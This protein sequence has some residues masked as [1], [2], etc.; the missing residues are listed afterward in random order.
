MRVITRHLKGSWGE[1]EFE[2][3]GDTAPSQTSP[4]RGYNKTGSPNCVWEMA[5][6]GGGGLI[7]RSPKGDKGRGGGHRCQSRQPRPLT[8]MNLRGG[9]ATPRAGDG[10]GVNFCS[11]GWAPSKTTGHGAWSR[12]GR[13][14]ESK[15]PQSAL[16]S[17][18][19]F[20][21]QPSIPT[22]N[23]RIV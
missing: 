22:K 7:E 14:F 6:G 10:E 1:I 16:R 20:N 13:L 21:D 2:K 11:L 23:D 5:R 9:L 12:Y 3:K 15:I 8:E 4:A 18:T 19:A 17:T